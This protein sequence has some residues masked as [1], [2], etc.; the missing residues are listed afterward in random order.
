MYT[1]GFRV[2]A[3]KFTEILPTFR[4]T[5]QSALL[6]PV[7]WYSKQVSGFPTHSRY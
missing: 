5:P 3:A 1:M 2:S 6:T 4:Q 7:F